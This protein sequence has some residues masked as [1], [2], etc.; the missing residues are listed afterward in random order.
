MVADAEAGNPHL[1]AA[2]LEVV[3]NQ[4]R[5]NDPPETK[6][7]YDR[8]VQEG[9]SAA[10]AKRLIGY[11]VASEIFDILKKQQEFNLQR[12]VQALKNLPDVPGD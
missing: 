3:E 1:K 12:F 8:L 10:D 6:Q 11:V 9:H 5:D 2:V 4:I 7:T